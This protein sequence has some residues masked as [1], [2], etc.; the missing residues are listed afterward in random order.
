MTLKAN[1]RPGNTEL[2]KQSVTENQSKN[3]NTTKN[4]DQEIRIFL[5]LLRYVFVFQLN[6][7]Q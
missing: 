3:F 7:T 2:H 5:F 1:K 6:S 4:P